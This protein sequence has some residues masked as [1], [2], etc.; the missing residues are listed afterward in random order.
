M[1][2]T[3]IL[4][5]LLVSLVWLAPVL[6]AQTPDKAP[7]TATEARLCPVTG[8]TAD[9]DVTWTYKNTSY[10]FCCAGCIPKF[11]KN[12]AKYIK[13]NTTKAMGCGHHE[14]HHK[15]NSSAEKRDVRVRQSPVDVAAVDVNGDGF[16][17]QDPMD[18]NVISDEEGDCP[19]CGMKL[20]EVSVK[21]AV[22]N[23]K[24]NGFSVQ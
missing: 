19:L 14:K 3:I 2:S 10:S 22:A 17:Y 21:E 12:P 15:E 24:K 20:K 16:V 18:W 13:A 23:L 5:T 1:R 11:K 7:A 6:R 9:P 8:E 4:T